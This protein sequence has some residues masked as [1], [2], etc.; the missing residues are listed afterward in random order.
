MESY[1]YLSYV[2][3]DESAI[4]VCLAAAPAANAT[5]SSSSPIG[6]RYTCHYMVEYHTSRIPGYTM[7]RGVA[8]ADIIRFDPRTPIV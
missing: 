4:S 6:S 1:P 3:E 7:P 5:S 8:S 2:Y